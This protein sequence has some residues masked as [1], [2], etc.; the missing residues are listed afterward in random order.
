MKQVIITVLIALTMVFS[1]GNEALADLS[2]GL[3]AHYSFNGNADD[4]SGNEL[5]GTVYGADL[6]ADRF[7]N[8]DSAYYFDGY[9]H[10]WEGP[11]LPET[12]NLILVADD[13]LLHFTNA[14]TVSV[15]VNAFESGPILNKTYWMDSYFLSFG[16]DNSATFNVVNPDGVGGYGI[17]NTVTAPNLE[18]NTWMHI[19]G[20]FGD[21]MAYI[22]INGELIDSMATAGDTLQDSDQ[23]VKMGNHPIWAAEDAFGG[24]LDEVR[25]YN[26]ALSSDEIGELAAVPIPGAV[27]LLGSGL[28]A[29]VGIRRRKKG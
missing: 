16:S 8:A 14:M 28:I 29:M 26:R 2:D 15:W 24:R 5:H 17:G 27:W 12:D 6:V 23:P 1:F 25:L 20:V 21:S 11:F 4:S 18:Y 7:G 19:A 10:K 3:V 9:D 22:Y 13:P